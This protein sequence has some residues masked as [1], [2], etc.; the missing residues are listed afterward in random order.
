M[1]FVR[2]AAFVVPLVLLLG[3]LSGRSV[4]SGS[5]NAWYVA[6]AKPGF[7]PP[8]WVF[9][10]AWTI[11]YVLIGFALAIAL[12]ARGAALRTAG[13]VLFAAQFALNLAWTPL[14]FGAHKVGAALFVIVLIFALSVATAW[15]FSRFRPTAAALMIPYIA[16]LAFAG[17]LNW[18]IVR[19]NPHADTIV[20]AGGTSQMIG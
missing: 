10:V 4:A 15:V 11:L 19:M 6:L 1:S 20:P 14:F 8:G 13:V 18:Q 9:P 7:T 17:V 12:S 5:E 2:W 3:F 16:W